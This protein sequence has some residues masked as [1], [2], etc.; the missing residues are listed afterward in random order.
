MKKEIYLPGTSVLLLF[1]FFLTPQGYL[2]SL[3]GN[4]TECSACNF[5]TA[6]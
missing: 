2:L 1:L 5:I 4:Y 3:K 6:V